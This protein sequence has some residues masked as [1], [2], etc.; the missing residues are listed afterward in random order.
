MEATEGEES[1]EAS[2]GVDGSNAELLQEHARAEAIRGAD[3]FQLGSKLPPKKTHPM[4]RHISVCLEGTVLVEA[5][6]IENHQ[7]RM[8]MLDQDMCTLEGEVQEPKS[9]ITCED[10]SP[11]D[12]ATRNLSADASSGFEEEDVNNSTCKLTCS[13][14]LSVPGQNSSSNVEEEKLAMGLYVKQQP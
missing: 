1:E 3:N 6:V 13:G 12:Q 14:L 4:V 8:A 2:V 11:I 9:M 5:T 7:G 10:P